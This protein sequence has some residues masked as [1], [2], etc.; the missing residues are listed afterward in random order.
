MT[1]EPVSRMRETGSVRSRHA[2]QLVGH[3]AAFVDNAGADDGH[4]WAGLITA[5]LHPRLTL[6]LS[7]GRG[8]QVAQAMCLNDCIGHH[9]A[10][11]RAAIA[12]TKADRLR[13]LRHA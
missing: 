3:V 9:C 10:P 8:H 4:E 1:A 13:C 2:G 6:G 7:F 11:S 12:G 5:M